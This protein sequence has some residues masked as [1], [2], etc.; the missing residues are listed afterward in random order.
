MGSFGV[1]NPHQGGDEKSVVIKISAGKEG[2]RWEALPRRLDLVRDSVNNWSRL[3]GTVTSR[4][5]GGE[6]AVVV[7][8]GSL[9]M[10]EERRRGRVG[11]AQEEEDDRCR[12]II[13]ITSDNSGLK[14]RSGQRE[15]R[16]QN[17]NS[18]S[19]SNVHEGGPENR[20][21]VLGHKILD[22]LE[23]VKNL[24]WVGPDH[25][26]HTRSGGRR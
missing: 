24:G 5:G 15:E 8:V 10:T 22:R 17:L 3:G 4:W 13:G 12:R 25:G 26:V 2:L 18:N 21:W 1:G 20:V 23:V 16:T 11:L 7:E 9:G 6:L 19:N 14:I